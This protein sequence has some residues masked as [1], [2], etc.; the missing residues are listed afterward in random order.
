MFTPRQSIV[1]I[2][3]LDVGG[4]LADNTK[5]ACVDDGSAQVFT[6]NLK[7]QVKVSYEIELSV[8]MDVNG[9]AGGR[10]QL[11][12]PCPARRDRQV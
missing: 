2:N 7:G 10:G 1:L 4:A 8:R 5:S 3:A 9:S 6:S 12:S 11:G